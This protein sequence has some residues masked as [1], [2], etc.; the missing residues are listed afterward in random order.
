MHQNN[1]GGAEHL[2]SKPLREGRMKDDRLVRRKCWVRV[3]NGDESVRKI[4]FCIIIFFWGGQLV[5]WIVDLAQTDIL[6]PTS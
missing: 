2:R 4:F 6:F 5:V 1:S 3:L